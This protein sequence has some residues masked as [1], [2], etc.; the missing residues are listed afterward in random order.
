MHKGGGNEG[1][2]GYRRGVRRGF[3]EERCL[4]FDLMCWRGGCGGIYI[5]EGRGFLGVG[6]KK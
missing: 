6:D 5:G 2:R 1:R 4:G 3:G